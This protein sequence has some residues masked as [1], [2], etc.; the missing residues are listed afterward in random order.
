MFVNIISP[1]HH[2]L[3]VKCLKKKTPRWNTQIN[4][5]VNIH[6]NMTNACNLSYDY[7]CLFPSADDVWI[8]Y[9]W[10]HKFITW[11]DSCEKMMY[12]SLDIDVIHVYEFF[13]FHDYR[14]HTIMEITL[15]VWP[16][17]GVPYTIS[18]LSTLHPFNSLIWKHTQIT[19]IMW[20][21]LIYADDT[22]GLSLILRN[23]QAPSLLIPS[24]QH[25]AACQVS[26]PTI[27]H[28]FSTCHE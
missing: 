6:C 1:N 16:V 25:N 9:W 15:S 5:L 19:C 3:K 14:C 20:I 26:F 13:V 21:L 24:A 18:D 2:S 8:A 17:E 27:S 22:K 28:R 10:R 7:L 12:D 23:K 11:R 4:M